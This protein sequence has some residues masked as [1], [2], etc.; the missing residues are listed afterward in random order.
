MTDDVKAK[1][2]FDYN[3]TSYIG[4]N[5]QLSGET[6]EHFNNAL[7]GNFW[8][9]GRLPKT[10]E[11]IRWRITSVETTDKSVAVSGCY[12]SGTK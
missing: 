9:E 5:I 8:C 2:S 12:E 3:A 6:A 4:F 11:Y 1:N 7:R 10:G